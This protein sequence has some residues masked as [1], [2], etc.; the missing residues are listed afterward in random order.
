[1]H[2]GSDGQRALRRNPGSRHGAVFLLPA[3][4]HTFRP[5]AQPVKEFGAVKNGVV[6]GQRLQLLR[7]GLTPERA[8]FVGASPDKLSSGGLVVTL[9]PAP[10]PSGLPPPTPPQVARVRLSE[11]CGLTS[12]SCP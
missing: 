1:M 11:R 5:A 7:H 12:Q 3:Q 8:F 9:S 10:S 2:R 6:P 4:A